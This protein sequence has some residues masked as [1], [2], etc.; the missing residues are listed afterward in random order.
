[1]SKLKIERT[2]YKRFVEAHI[3]RPYQ[4]MIF[5]NESR[6]LHFSSDFYESIPELLDQYPVWADHV[7]DRLAQI[8]DFVEFEFFP[9]GTPRAAITNRLFDRGVKIKW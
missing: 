9:T 7:F 3:L 1:M 2:E 8:F 6:A 5:P 4:D